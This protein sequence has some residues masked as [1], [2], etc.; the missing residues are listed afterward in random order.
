MNKTILLIFTGGT[1]TM[2]SGESQTKNILHDNHLELIEKIKPKISNVNF[3]FVIYS[4]LP[5]PSIT[6]ND[7][8][9]IAKIIDQKNKSMKID[10]VVITHGTDT[11]EETAFFLDLYCNLDIP[12]VVTGSMRT[13]DEFGYDGL[14]NL[15]S[16]ILVALDE[17]SVNR[18]V[19][20][21]LNDEIN[22]ALEVQKTHTM[23]LDTFK[24][25]EFGPLG[26]VDERTV[27]YYRQATYKNK[28]IK[29]TSINKKVEIVKVVSGSDG[30]IIDYYIDKGVD[31]LII[32][33][34]GRGN[35]PVSV[36]NKI[37]KAINNDITVVITSK[38]PM[39]MVKGSYS[40]EGGGYH[41][42]KLGALN[43]STLTSEK[44]RLK[45]LLV[46]SSNLDPKEYF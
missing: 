12:I 14:S 42:H 46:L 31:G 34:L 29:P 32:E 36:A 15:I 21:C 41:L 33:A 23:A 7:M 43:G 38:C 30:D 26:I 4:V 10:G 39:G 18:G 17:N 1:I 16:S 8:L 44:A 25:L 35:V 6:P 3:E 28:T 13:F 5:S 20:V 45:L 40:Y 22:S 37:E 19:L 24:S 11:L 2:S 27:S 9:E